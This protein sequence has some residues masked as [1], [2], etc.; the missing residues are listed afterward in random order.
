M[1]LTPT[2][3]LLGS[4]GAAAALAAAVSF[5]AQA[6]LPFK[7]CVAAAWPLCGCALV[8]ALSPEDGDV[9]RALSP[10]ER[11]RLAQVRA[12]NVAG[13]EALRAASEGKG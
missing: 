13:L 5:R 10:D 7:L 11:A 2:A 1:P 12:A 6:T 8:L 9:R 4:A 3:A